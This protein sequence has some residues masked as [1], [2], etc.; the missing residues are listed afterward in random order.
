MQRPLSGQATLALDLCCGM[1]GPSAGQ[2][3]HISP[4][5]LLAF[6]DLVS[7]YLKCFSF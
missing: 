7:T 4:R 1:E 2:G 5:L 3:P 6:L